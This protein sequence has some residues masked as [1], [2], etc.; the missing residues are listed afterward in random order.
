MEDEELEIDVSNVF[1]AED[2]FMLNRC[3]IKERLMEYMRLYS[4]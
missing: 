2:A 1:C 4:V 3:K